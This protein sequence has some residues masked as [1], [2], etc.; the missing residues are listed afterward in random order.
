MFHD[1]ELADAVVY[2]NLGVAQCVGRHVPPVVRPGVGLVYDAHM[3]DLN[4]AKVLVG[5]AARYDVSLIAIWKLHRHAERGSGEIPPFHY[6]VLCG[7]QVN[8][9]RLLPPMYSSRLTSS[10]KYCILIVSIILFP[11]LIFMRS[12]APSSHSP[13]TPVLRSRAGSS[14]LAS[15]AGY[16]ADLFIWAVYEDIDPA[17][18]LPRFH[19][20]PVVAGIHPD[21]L[22][23][24]TAADLLCKRKDLCLVRC[25]QRI[26]AAECDA[27]NIR[28]CKLSKELLFPSRRT[29]VLP[30]DPMSPDSGTPDNDGCSRTP[31]VRRAVHRHSACHLFVVMISHRC[32]PHSKSLTRIFILSYL[33]FFQPVFPEL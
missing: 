25:M 23:R 4:D 12:A 2:L 7:S 24:K 16:H 17:C 13:V 29:K 18:D 30:S 15:A 10:F 20:F 32:S 26:A 31:R 14:F 19:I 22:S 1:T 9:V 28:L 5:R 3:V 6:N 21:R 8:P 33:C 27:G 11:L